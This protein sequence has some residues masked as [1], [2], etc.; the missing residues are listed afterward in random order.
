MNKKIFK[1][2]HIIDNYEVDHIERLLTKGKL[3]CLSEAIKEYSNFSIK[4]LIV[5]TTQPCKDNI[6][7]YHE[8]YTNQ[9]SLIEVTVT[10][11]N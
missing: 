2:Q 11:W 1:S 5:D 8:H 4:T 7:L 9:T 3:S 6:E 10:A